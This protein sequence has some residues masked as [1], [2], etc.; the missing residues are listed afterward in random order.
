MII[1][2]LGLPGTGKSTLANELM[3]RMDAVW[4]DGDAVRATLSS[5]LGFS[6]ADRL[7][8]ARRMGA[9]AQLLDGRDC[10]VSFICPTEETRAAFGERDLTIWMDRLACRE[11]DDTTAMFEPP[12]D[13]DMVVRDGVSV[14]SSADVVMGLVRNVRGQADRKRLASSIAASSAPT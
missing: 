4:L 14:T 5:D 8:H 9:V 10:I 1:L 11:F 6:H 13:Y 12:A 2:I 7:E 3:K